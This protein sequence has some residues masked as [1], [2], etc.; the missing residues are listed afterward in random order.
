MSIIEDVILNISR[1][2][3]ERIVYEIFTE[4]KKVSEYIIRLN[5]DQLRAGEY[6][7]GEKIITAAGKRDGTKSY[8]KSYIPRRKK[9]GLPADRV[10]LNY[11][12]DFYKTLKTV[13]AKKQGEVFSRDKKV[14]WLA[15]WPE[16]DMDKAFQISNDSLALLGDFITPYIIEKLLN[17]ILE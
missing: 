17:E 11:D 8:S 9:K 16:I 3:L 10:T 1:I 7:T 15:G 6:G 4:E 2:D 5:Q 12:G 13:F 14:E